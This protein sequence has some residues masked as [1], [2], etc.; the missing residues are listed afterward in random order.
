MSAVFEVSGSVSEKKGTCESPENA[1]W[2]NSNTRLR[3]SQ[4]RSSTTD[5]KVGSKWRE[6][7]EETEIEKRE[8]K[9]RHTG[10]WAVRG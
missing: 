5:S 7:E 9:E 10:W 3:G 8:Q 4:G 6:R 1:G 2:G